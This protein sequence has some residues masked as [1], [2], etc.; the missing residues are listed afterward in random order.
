MRNKL[1]SVLRILKNQ[2]AI[3]QHFITSEQKS[4]FLR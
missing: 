4:D 3:D 2:I 1:N